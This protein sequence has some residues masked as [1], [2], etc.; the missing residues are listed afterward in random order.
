MARDF[1][2]ENLINVGFRGK[3]AIAGRVRGWWLRRLG[4]FHPGSGSGLFFG[5]GIRLQN[6]RFIQMGQGVAFG[7]NARIECFAHED[8]ASTSP[9]LTIGT[10]TT[11]G[12]GIHIG[13]INRVQIGQNVLLGSYILIVD[14]SHGQPGKDI[15]AQPI[16]APRLRPIISKAGIIIGDNVWIGDGAVILPGAAIGD[17]AV[18]GANAVVRGVVEARTIFLGAVI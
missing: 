18:I 14:H 16:T 15:K 11:F 6:P 8:I 10:G 7:C 4:F 3:R 2:G 17:G 1:S 13:C 9:K 5:A 12:D